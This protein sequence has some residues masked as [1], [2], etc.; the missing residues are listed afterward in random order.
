MFQEAILNGQKVKHQVNIWFALNFFLIKFQLKST[1]NFDF[2]GKL[3]ENLD[4]FFMY[5]K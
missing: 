4:F 1:D 5:L 3:N 2:I